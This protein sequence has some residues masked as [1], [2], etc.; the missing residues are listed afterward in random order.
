M[1]N[2]EVQA[3]SRLTSEQ[4]LEI[5]RCMLEARLGDQREESLH[6]QGSGWF[7]LAGTGHEA[8]AA[9]GRLLKE[10]DYLCPF[11]R[12]RALVLAKGLTTYE[13]ALNFLAKRDSSSGGRQLP[14][15]FSSRKK[16]VWSLPSPVGAHLLPACGIAW[17][18]Q[19]DESN[20]V[21]VAT[22]GEGSAR[23]G[24]FHEAACF[25][26]E[27]NLPI[28]F[29]VE[30]N[31]ISISMHNR[32]NNPLALGFLDTSKWM[33]IDGTDI[34]AV[35]AAAEFSIADIR[36]GRGPRFVWAT[37]PRMCSHSCADDHRQYLP[38]EELTALQENDPL[39][40]YRQR[41]TGDGIVAEAEL[42]SMETSLKEEIRETYAQADKATDPNPAEAE[43]HLLGHP[44]EPEI[45]SV[46]LQN[47][48][49]K[50]VETVNRLFH[51]AVETNPDFIFFGEDVEDPK[52]GV[53][54]LTEG[55]STK[56]PSNAFNSPVAEST[57]LGV[58]C[59]LASY[60]KRPIAE[61]QFIDFIAPGWNQLVSNI[62]TLRWRTFGDWSCPM[63]IYAPSGAYL[64]GGGPWHSQ[65]NEGDFARQ[66]GLQVVVPSTPED[67]AGLTWSAIHGADPVIV[68]LPKHLLW[69]SHKPISSAEAIP[70]GKARKTH[71]G[72]N[73]T[74]LAWGNC[75]EIVDE[76]LLQLDR[77][78]AEV[79]DLRSLVPWDRDLVRNSVLKTGRLLIVQE[80]TGPGSIGQMLVAELLE[81]VGVHEAL[82]APP[83]VVSRKNVHVGYNPIYEYESL[84][85]PTLVADA[86]KQLTSGKNTRSVST[87][88]LTATSTSKDP[89]QSTQSTQAKMAETMHTVQV[90]ILGEGIQEARIVTLHKQPG[91]TVVLDDALC[92]VETAKAVFPVESSVEGV[93]KEWLIE[94][95]DDVEVGQKLALIQLSNGVAES[96]PENTTPLRTQST[97]PGL[98]REAREQL[99]AVVQAT[100]NVDVSWEPIRTA[101][102][103]AK[104][105]FGADA[106]SPSLMVAWAVV[107]A[108]K[109]NK[110][111]TS[112]LEDE[113]LRM[114]PDDF[115]F[116]IAVALD[117]D[118]L[119]TAVIEHANKL[120]FKDFQSAYREAI[121][122]VREGKS[123]TKVRVPLIISSMGP[124][125]IRSATPVV[126]PPSI[127]T[128][129]VG[130][131]HLEP[132][133]EGKG[134]GHQE[135]V[136]MD[137]T[138]DHRWINGVG[139]ASFMADIRKGVEEF[140][141][142][143]L[144]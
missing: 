54:K 104:A 133:V 77:P 96:E 123:P 27:K 8:M 73:L 62:A 141:L 110:P 66:P 120:S 30:D 113:G 99:Q 59:G 143:D 17:G 58:S 109:H 36:N 106:P 105:E 13:L 74:I 2:K 94:E 112:L 22:L 90:P 52:G 14:S 31:G 101:R 71:E 16:N 88:N 139:A 33:Q 137:L 130:T 39:R 12:D 65:S 85:S 47:K 45:L 53:F 138:F 124:Y 23:Q 93:L 136:T 61:I 70:I 48:P 63:V 87:L 67:A 142:P 115:D 3:S 81:E 20:G 24:D 68:L 1:P 127:A 91:D 34:D 118:A 97:H 119:E 10:E 83:R 51:A 126:V 132:I 60:G 121:R 4:H 117:N 107:Q 144:S 9:L 72:K 102:R 125:H 64:P 92:E 122:T 49:K 5:Y 98:S 108:M 84:P 100:V 15:H 32:E 69:T 40:L 135:V 140:E 46:P 111:F 28:L 6:R 80:D 35:H 103:K 29:W 19:L 57:I 131:S 86:I 75:L 55:L 95:E 41:L 43:L 114:Q 79:I 78:D 21:A 11:Y 42:E 129:F 56:Y 26:L 76:A 38:K 37:V 7:Q 25:A 18:L 44:V 89:S 50:M 116:G 82:K 134:V 128:L